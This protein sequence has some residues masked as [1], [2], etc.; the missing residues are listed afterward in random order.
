MGAPESTS[1]PKLAC[2]PKAARAQIKQ[3]LP[4]KRVLGRQKESRTFRRFLALADE[5]T[6]EKISDSRNM[7]YTD[8]PPERL[9]FRCHRSVS[10]LLISSRELT[11]RL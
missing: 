3:V 2:A 4:V 11:G 6:V 8:F 7:V 9:L 10:V 1:A 5:V